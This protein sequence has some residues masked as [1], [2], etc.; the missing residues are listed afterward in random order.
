M[1]HI[2]KVEEMV[3]P[4]MN[5]LT[6]TNLALSDLYSKLSENP[7]AESPNKLQRKSRTF[8]EAACA[9]LIKIADTIEDE[10]QKASFLGTRVHRRI[11]DKCNRAKL[12]DS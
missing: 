1:E 7:A 8:L 12:I 6:Q 4:G 11:L 10:D 5:D 9:S 3:C 2:G